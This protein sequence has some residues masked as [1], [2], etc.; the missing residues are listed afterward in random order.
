MLVTPSKFTQSIS[1]DSHSGS[2]G[3]RNPSASPFSTTNTTCAKLL[4]RT[5]LSREQLAG[6]ARDVLV[7]LAGY[8]PESLA[9][10]CL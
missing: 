7:S 9:T 10:R 1:A 8:Q 4:E 6:K 3:I 2:S 5:A